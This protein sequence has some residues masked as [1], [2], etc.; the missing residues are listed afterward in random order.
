MLDARGGFVSTR[1]LFCSKTAGPTGP[2]T[3]LGLLIDRLAQRHEVQVLFPGDGAFRESL[4]RK[5]VPYRSVSSLGRRSVP[6]L[7]T[8]V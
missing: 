5:G 1:I 4:E 2:T 8:W 6:G 7:A 3:S